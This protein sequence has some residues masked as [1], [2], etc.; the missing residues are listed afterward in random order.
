MTDKE[1][2]RAI[3]Q[4]A[5]DH[6]HE[7]F[8]D[9]NELEVIRSLGFGDRFYYNLEYLKNKFYIK[10]EDASGQ[11]ISIKTS[12]IDL[13]EDRKRFDQLFPVSFH[14]PEE[15]KKLVR[16]VENL[17]RGRYD[18][19]LDQFLK[20]RMFLYDVVPP[21]AV[22]CT[23]EAVG[24]VEAL[25]KI[26]L[27]QPSCTLGELSRQLATGYMNHAAMEKIIHGIYGVAS[28]VPGARH[29][30]H[31]KTDFDA[32]DAEFILNVSAAIILYLA[33]SK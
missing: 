14:I 17:L 28:D 7:R 23:K 27:N 21:D 11:L 3:L 22:N 15:T 19:V 4:F 16:N 13:V 1:I 8:I 29:G 26:L 2:Q 33:G 32:S 10:M 9:L 18:S 6:R 24:A 20:A 5:Y 30:A 31:R 25:A 12:A